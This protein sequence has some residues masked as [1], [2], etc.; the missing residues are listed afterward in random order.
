M[1]WQNPDVQ[2]AVT[3]DG[4]EAKIHFI[5]TAPANGSWADAAAMAAA[6]P[7]LVFNYADNATA[8]SSFD[9]HPATAASG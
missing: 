8:G 1:I 3:Y 7:T 4:F 2:N 6:P 5:H 9:I